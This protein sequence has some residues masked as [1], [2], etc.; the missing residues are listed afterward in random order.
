MEVNKLSV[1]LKSAKQ[2]VKLIV[3]NYDLERKK[4]EK[5]I[6]Y[7]YEY[8]NKHDTEAREL[9]KTQKKILK[10]ARKETKKVAED[11]LK[12][13]ITEREAIQKKTTNNPE[14]HTEG[15]NKKNRARQTNF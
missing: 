5:E 8:K 9:K 3:Q 14:Y 4:V 1:A 15:T 10:K 7:L 13:L 6:N 11:E 2:E 12:K